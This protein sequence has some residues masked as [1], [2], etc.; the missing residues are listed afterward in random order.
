MG[1]R[2]LCRIQC[3][4]EDFAGTHHVVIFRFLASQIWFC[5][6]IGAVDQRAAYGVCLKKNSYLVQWLR[7][8]YLNKYIKTVLISLKRSVSS[9]EKLGCSLC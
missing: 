8:R 7:M 1:H 2:V 5:E 4:A 9:V 3:R 6:S